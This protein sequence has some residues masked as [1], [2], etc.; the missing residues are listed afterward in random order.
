MV[1]TYNEIVFSLKMQEIIIFVCFLGS[2][3]QH[4]E[5]PRPGVESELKFLAYTTATETQDLS[6]VCDLHHRLRQC[7]ILNPLVKARDQTRNLVLPSQMFPLCQNRNS[8]REEIL[9]HSTTWMNLEDIM[10]SKIS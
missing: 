4:M 3:L 5:V 9:I 1:Y 2:S 6:C 10:L 8:K 7:W